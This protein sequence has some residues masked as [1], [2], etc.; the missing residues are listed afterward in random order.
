MKAHKGLT[1]CLWLLLMIMAVPEPVRPHDIASQRRQLHFARGQAEQALWMLECRDMWD[2][3][4]DDAGVY[5]HILNTTQQALE[6]V[7]QILK[8]PGDTRVLGVYR[9]DRDLASQGPGL[10][11]QQFLALP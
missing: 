6:E 10:T 3:A 2:S 11:A 9:L 5:F 7:R 1:G 8:N 4:D